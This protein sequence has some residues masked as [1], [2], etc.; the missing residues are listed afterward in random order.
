MQAPN[1][2]YVGT[3]DAKKWSIVGEGFPYAKEYISKEAV[4]RW[5]GQHK[6]NCEYDYL[7]ARIFELIE[8]DFVQWLASL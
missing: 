4:M 3:I 7:A 2:I 6:Q 1:K 8:D 5:F